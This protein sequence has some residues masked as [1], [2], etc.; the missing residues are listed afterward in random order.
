MDTD[1]SARRQSLRAIGIFML[2][3][4]IVVA[5]EGVSVFQRFLG[6]TV[7]MDEVSVADLR[8]L[9]EGSGYQVNELRGML[10]SAPIRVGANAFFDEMD[11]DRLRVAFRVFEH[12]VS[13]GYESGVRMVFFP[14]G[15]ELSFFHFR[16][17]GVSSMTIEDF[18]RLIEGGG[19][20]SLIVV[21]RSCYL[22]AT[23]SSRRAE[24]YLTESWRRKW[25]R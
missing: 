19:N 15:E 11:H 14:L 10:K 24:I 2:F 1:L 12:S 9:F 25:M 22:I 21:A 8:T 13:N 23:L 18:N 5:G 4:D 17:G 16:E 6:N 20:G 3:C 7:K